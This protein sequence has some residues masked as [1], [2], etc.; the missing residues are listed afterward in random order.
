[1]QHQRPRYLVKDLD[2]LVAAMAS[3]RRRLGFSQLAFDDRVGLA[4]GHTAKIEAGWR[5]L[6][7]VS[8]PNML[9]ALGCVL[10]LMPASDV[11]RA[12]TV[13]VAV[14][15]RAPRSRKVVVNG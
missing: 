1:M 11:S 5:G 7:Q 8:L 13:P 15:D 12:F 3:E 6:G 2:G 14:R 4:G 9:D 10:V